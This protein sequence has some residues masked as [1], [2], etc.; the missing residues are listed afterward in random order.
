M[1]DERDEQLFRRAADV[2]RAPGA[3][4]DDALA[5][6]IAAVRHEATDGGIGAAA[7]R[8]AVVSRRRGPLMGG[9]ARGTARGTA[10]FIAGLAAGVAFAAGLGIGLYSGWR[11]RGA[12]YGLAAD[13]VMMCGALGAAGDVSPVQFMLIAPAATRVALVG[14]FNDWDP[15][16]TPM[17]RATGGAWHVAVPLANGRHVYAFVVDGSAWVSDPQA[18]IAPERWFGASNS[19]LLVNGVQR[20]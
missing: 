8:G 2:L 13:E 18:P 5:D 11:M 17:S 4:D 6:A 7:L 16:A 3:R 9:M 19:V 15:Q 20:Q 10:R 14:E 1:T 12:S